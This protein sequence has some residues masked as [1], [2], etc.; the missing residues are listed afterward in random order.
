MELTK[1]TAAL[2]AV[3]LLAPQAASAAQDTQTKAN[4]A[5]SERRICETYTVTGS[6]LAT[7]RVCGTAEEWAER[8]LQDRQ[9]VEKVQTNP[10]VITRTSPTGRA[11]C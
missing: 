9:A 3:A 6:R 7:K 4:P 5:S 1:M 2:A 11:A 8:R 10:C